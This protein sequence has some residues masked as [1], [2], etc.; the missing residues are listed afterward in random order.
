MFLSELLSVGQKRIVKQRLKKFAVM[1]MLVAI[2]ALTPLFAR[3][4]YENFDY[5]S[6]GYK[7]LDYLIDN[8]KLEESGFVLP[9]SPK[10]LS[11]E[12]EFSIGSFSIIRVTLVKEESTDMFNNPSVKVY[13]IDNEVVY[14]S[15]LSGKEYVI[16]QLVRYI[17]VMYIAAKTIVAFLLGGTMLRMTT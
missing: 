13:A 11:Q 12:K 2:V 17:S 14:R 8:C 1:Y 15:K 7:Y 16:I 6:E 10:G 4:M 9:E 5:D 3:L